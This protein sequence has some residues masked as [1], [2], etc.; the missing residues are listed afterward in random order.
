M[1]YRLG[2]EFS[3]DTIMEYPRI[4]APGAVHRSRTENQQP[5]VNKGLDKASF[6]LKN[7][8]V[9]LQCD[10]GEGP[11]Y[12]TGFFVNF[13]CSTYDVILTAAHNLI[14]NQKV[15][16][17]DLKVFCAKSEKNAKNNGEGP[18]K[19]ETEPEPVA[20]F[21]ICPQYIEI[22]ETQSKDSDK[23]P[24]A[25]DKGSYDYGIILLVKDKTKESN[26]QGLGLNLGLSSSFNL[27]GSKVANVCGYGGNDPSSP[28]QHSSGSI[29]SSGKQCVEYKA[30]TEQG[31]S[32]AP[33]WIPYGG[34]PMVVGIHNMRPKI[35]TGGS[36]GTKITEEVFRTICAW[37]GIG[38][39]GKRLCAIGKKNKPHNTYLSFFQHSDFAKVF[40]GS[41]EEATNQDNVTF[42]IMPTTIFPRWTG[43]QVLYAFKFH[44]PPA[45]SDEK[46]CWVEWQPKQQRAI[47]VDTLKDVNLVRLD[48]K[49]LKTGKKRL[50]VLIPAPGDVSKMQELRLYDDDRDEDDIE[51]GMTEFAGV[52]FGQ[53]GDR[54]DMVG[55][56]LFV[57]E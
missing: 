40:L 28:L 37:L 2:I 48:E 51:D 45:W 11:T 17:Q 27:Q 41:S 13:P 30:P 7:S 3:S 21:K 1:L 42:D 33:V 16:V 32:G 6:D 8:I 55:S 29:K 5:D 54:A 4:I 25:P 39:F 38:F 23:G 53:W 50:L 9:R 12:G 52:S 57:I 56:R 18:G 34:H 20:G 14:N 44:R 19:D 43:R 26:R 47:L 35:K 49:M 22:L 15:T 24:K 10:F 46:K 31:M 36:R